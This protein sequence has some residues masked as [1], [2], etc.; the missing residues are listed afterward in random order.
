MATS[1]PYIQDTIQALI[2]IGYEIGEAAVDDDDIE[3]MAKELI[4][5]VGKKGAISIIMDL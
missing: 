5:R 4:K 3:T 1:K 2:N